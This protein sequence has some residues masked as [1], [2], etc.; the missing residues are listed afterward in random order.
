MR[1][2]RVHG[3]LGWKQ[4]LSP[5]SN[6]QASSSKGLIGPF[7]SWTIFFQTKICFVPLN[8]INSWFVSC[9]FIVLVHSL[10][11]RLQS[12][13]LE[14]EKLERGIGGDNTHLR[15]FLF[16]MPSLSNG[17]L[18]FSCLALAR[19]TPWWWCSVRLKNRLIFRR[20][21]GSGT[22]TKKRPTGGQPR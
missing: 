3:G 20:S 17:I 21:Q 1:L 10:L 13:L 12:L 11:N 22:A 7:F 6:D 16:S 14:C 19:L 8:V 9:G 18:F 5:V 15:S 2:N 4:S